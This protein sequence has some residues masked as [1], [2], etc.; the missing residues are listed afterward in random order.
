MNITFAHLLGFFAFLSLLPFIIIYFIK[1]K[2]RTLEIP[3][4]MFFK[5]HTK[6]STIKS[7][8]RY[9]YADLLFILQLLVLLFLSFS[10]ASPSLVLQRDIV[11]QHLV[12]VLDVSASSQVL[13]SEHTTRLDVAKEKIKTLAASKNSLILLSSRPVLAL[14][15]ASKRELLAYLDRVSPTDGLSDLGSSLN[16]AGELLKKQ[17]GRVVVLSDFIFSKGVRP[18][19]TK[20]I[21]ETE[22]ISVDFISTKGTTL[23]KNVG[24]TDLLLTP[25]QVNLYL[26][27]Y[28]NFTSPL[29][30]KVNH[31]T[32]PLRLD[33]QAVHPFVFTLGENLTKVDILEKDD[34]DADNHVFITK[35]YAEKIRVLLISTTPSKF[36]KAVLTSLPEV[37]LVVATPPIISSDSFDLYIIDNVRKDALV[38]D[39]FGS[40]FRKI[41]ETGGAVIVMTQPDLDT[42]NFEGLLPLQFK[43]K[44]KSGPSVVSQVT[45]FTKEIDFGNVNNAFN[46][47]SNQS[48]DF[49]KVHDSSVLSLFTFGKGKVLY[50]G[51]NDLTNDFKLTPDYPIFWSSV[52]LS[53]TGRENL[54]LFNLKTGTLFERGNETKN[55]DKIGVYEF[56]DTSFAVNLLNEKESDINFIDSAVSTTVSHQ[57]LTP[58]KTDVSYD[59]DFYLALFVLLLLLIEFIYINYRG[60]L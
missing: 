16:F 13:E 58:L 14:Q 24:I 11:S 41:K 46:V 18:E 22:G 40:I 28:N 23:R 21:L 39:T 37:Q 30:L 10:I 59:L 17:K 31:L 7:L 42:L 44:M 36:L 57:T 54:N 5:T 53:L 20:K 26:K 51:I 9:F 55:L 15:D 2:P 60:E 12:F 52:I 29:T 8:F 49:V 6:I 50:Y 38:V 32:Y 43:G 35:P 25:Q 48:I 34:F 27:N 1:P 33:A 56:G 3:S 45:S 47:S 4:L 19:L